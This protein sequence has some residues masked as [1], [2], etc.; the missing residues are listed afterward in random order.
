MI[1][2]IKV[3]SYTDRKRLRLSFGKHEEKLRI[4]HF[5]FVQLKSYYEFIN[6][7]RRGKSKLEKLLQKMFPIHGHSK[8]TRLDYLEYSLGPAPF[9]PL[10]C[11]ARGLTYSAPLKFKLFLY[12]VNRVI[13]KNNSDL[14][15]PSNVY[16]L[17][18]PLMTNRGTFIINGAE[19]AVVSQIHKS[20]GLYFEIDR[21]K[22]SP[23][24]PFYVAKIV[25]H[26]GLWIDFEFDSKDCIYVRIDKKKKF[27]VTTFLLAL[28]LSDQDVLKFFRQKE[29]ESARNNGKN[30]DLAIDKNI[31]ADVKNLKNKKDLRHDLN[32]YNNIFHKKKGKGKGKQRRNLNFKIDDLSSEKGDVHY[33]AYIYNTFD[34][35]EVKNKIEAVMEVHRIL[36]P[37]EPA[38]KETAKY[39]VNNLFFNEERYNLS[40]IGRKKIN[41]KLELNQTTLSLTRDDILH[42]IK[43]LI[44]IKSGKDQVDDID[45][46]GNRRVKSIGEM[47]G[48]LFRSAFFRM[49]RSI[50]ER[51]SSADNQNLRPQDVVNTK[52]ISNSI[53]EFFCSSQLSQFMDQTNPLAEITHKRRLSALGPGGLSRERA[54]FEVRDV[55]S[56][57]YGRICP[58]ET[59]EG[60]NIGLINSLTIYSR[61]NKYGFL[62]TPYIIVKNR[63]VTNEIKYLGADDEGDVIIAQADV[64]VNKYNKI[65]D[66]LVPCRFKGEFLMAD[67]SSI[68]YMDISPKQIVSVSTGFIP[69]L[70]HNDANRALM[71]SNM[72][73]QA[74]PLLKPE[75]PLV[76]TGMEKVIAMDD[77]VTVAA[78]RGGYVHSVD[79]S[80]IIIKANPQEVEDYIFGVDVYK[81]LKYMRTNQNTCIN[82]KPLVKVGDKIRRGDIIADGPSTDLGELALGQNLL[83]AFMPWNGYNF[84]DSI[85]LSENLVKNNKLTSLHVEEFVCTVRESKLGP[86][87]ITSDIPNVSDRQL[88]NLD[89]FGIVKLG[90]YVKQG[91]ILIGKI[92]KKPETQISPEEKLLYAIFG[93]KALNVDNTSLKVPVSIK[94]AVIDIQIFNRYGANK[95]QRTLE[96]E[97]IRFEDEKRHYKD[98][99]KILRLELIEQIYIYL[100]DYNTR[101]SQ[102]ISLESVVKISIDDYKTFELV[103]QRVKWRIYLKKVEIENLYKRYLRRVAELESRFKEGDDLQP[104]VIKLVKVAIA[105]RKRIQIGDKMS[106]RH[107]NKGVV[108]II[109]PA[110]DM[111]YLSN[112]KPVDVVLN[113]LGVPSRMNIGQVLETHLGWACKILG[114]KI[115]IMSEHFDLNYIKIKQFL[116]EL[117]AIGKQDVI[118]EN[119]SVDAIKELVN[120]LKDGV[121]ISTPAF[122]GIT[123]KDVKNLLKMAGLPESGKAVLYDGRTGLP[124]DNK[125]TVGYQYLMKLNHLIDD[126]MH[127]RATG[128]YSLISQQPLGGKAQFG[129][130]RFGEMEVWALEAYGAAYTLQEMLTVKSD[131]ITGR[132]K[133]Y[134]NIISGKHVMEPG[135]PEAFNVLSREIL[136]L[137]LNIELEYN[138]V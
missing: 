18:M 52:L 119:M 24:K 61:I 74:T 94:G 73:R 35:D 4:P 27:L 114:E 32:N 131:D 56:T 130:Q 53:R 134:K 46:L 80:R 41:E 40:K 122:D 15:D 133:I 33:T 100:R 30:V 125:V 81:L 20:A 39:T 14:N 109:V 126:K 104:G 90:T 116:C 12:D 75:K 69:F 22:S 64:K 123:E 121:P 63:K 93:E 118:I 111:P 120:N 89:E 98:E 84:E 25:P 124:F 50:K 58:I 49:E 102:N 112:G 44:D 17:D 115:S 16:I 57:H 99:F 6:F 110:E 8:T 129:G 47:L 128:S 48:N 37:G 59:P 135:I 86:E 51:L 9:D 38:T 7:S 87:E 132:T 105:T 55:H 85:I 83:V 108:S 36:K 107:G 97:K 137:G 21:S 92:T 43:R 77:G 28:D 70:E 2:K 66:E 78:R 62:E 54:G 136:S 5:Y 68:Q 34:T 106:G 19:R 13:T 60:P 117:Y 26:R 82:Q 1:N 91:D 96:L 10:E 113:P 103:D 67:P 101:Y 72:Q 42:T 95:D 127:A 76:G 71:G 23:N 88:K 45:H 3:L 29:I 79:S 138:E 31:F 65:D 11:K